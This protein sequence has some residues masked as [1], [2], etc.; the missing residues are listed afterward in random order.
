MKLVRKAVKPVSA[1]LALT[2]VFLSGPNQTVM[3]AIIGT[4]T[5]LNM[6]RRTAAREFLDTLLAREDIRTALIVQGIDQ[7]E[8]MNRIDCLSDAE[9]EYIADRLDQLPQGG[10]LETLLVVALIVFFT[11]LITD[12][13][14][15]TDVFP[16]VREDGSKKINR[17]TTAID[18]GV[19]TEAYSSSKN[20]QNAP[21]RNLVIYFKQ[22]SNELS[23]EAITKLDEIYE[24]ML[25]HPEAEL[26][27]V[28]F[29]DA[30]QSP[31][32][33]K[34]L[35]ENRVYAVK[36]YLVGKG[37]SPNRTKTALNSTQENPPANGV[38]VTISIPPGGEK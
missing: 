20:I 3:A 28:G 35:S 5:V 21:A 36:M 8:A 34:V 17:E 26:D 7:K 33:Y 9:V 31:A 16:F 22:N 6:D 18:T 32:Y 4:E 38:E 29:T 15:Y 2:M 37:L 14:G 11:L 25:G 10:A 1:L 13:A 23:D 12:I 19:K 27:I 24:A 30:Q